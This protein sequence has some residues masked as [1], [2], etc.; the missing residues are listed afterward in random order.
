VIVRAI[1]NIRGN[2]SGTYR[3]LRSSIL[4]N[5]ILFHNERKKASNMKIFVLW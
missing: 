4:R 1:K 5:T 3:N 2:N